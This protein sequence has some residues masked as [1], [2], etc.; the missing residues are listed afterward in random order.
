MQRQLRNGHRICMT[1]AACAANVSYCCT[2]ADDVNTVYECIDTD[3]WPMSID[4][5]TQP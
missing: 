3:Q 1:T 4:A 5:T 2:G